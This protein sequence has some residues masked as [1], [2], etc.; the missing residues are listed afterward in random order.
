MRVQIVLLG[1]CSSIGDEKSVLC[2]VFM[3]ELVMRD[4][5]FSSWFHRGVAGSG[6]GFPNN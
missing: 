3:R 2:F 4:A 5:A 6:L 1:G